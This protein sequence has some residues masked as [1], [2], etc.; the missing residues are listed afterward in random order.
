MLSTLTDW[1]NVVDQEEEDD[2]EDEDGQ[3]GDK[4]QPQAAAAAAGENGSSTSSSKAATGKCSSPPNPHQFGPS[5]HD[6][7]VH[8]LLDA[9]LAPV[10]AAVASKSANAV[11]LRNVAAC[12]LALM[13]A[14]AGAGGH[15]GEHGTRPAGKGAA[16]VTA[17]LTNPELPAGLVLRGGAQCRAQAELIK[18]GGE[19]EERG[20]GRRESE[21]EGEGGTG[22]EVEVEGRDV[23]MGR[24]RLGQASQGD[25]G[26]EASMPPLG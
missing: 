4:A 19:E 3:G 1:L 6:A 11:A 22:V 2:D 7:L 21:G 5:E 18:V 25:Q 20:G 26:R 23:G 9:G 10:L 12:A 24:R 8:G 16:A 13:T 17:A 15:G 14:G